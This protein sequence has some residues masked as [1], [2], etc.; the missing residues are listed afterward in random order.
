MVTFEK[1]GRLFT[2][3]FVHK[4]I[5]VLALECIQ[6]D[7]NGAWY[8]EEEHERQIE[9]CQNGFIPKTPCRNQSHTHCIVSWYRSGD[10]KGE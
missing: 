6:C 4:I 10:S 7:K 3:H 2:T 1:N 8:S 5:E 9:L